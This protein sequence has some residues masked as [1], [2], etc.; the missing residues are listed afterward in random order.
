LRWS[1]NDGHRVRIEMPDGEHERKVLARQEG[2]AQVRR[3]FEARDGVG[4]D[5]R[6]TTREFREERLQTMS[7]GLGEGDRA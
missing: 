5:K 1:G 4:R 6:A 7:L 3:P 2:L